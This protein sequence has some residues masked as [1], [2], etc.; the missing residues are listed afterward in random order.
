MP[1]E[2]TEHWRRFFGGVAD[3]I[4]TQLRPTTVLDA[5]CAKGFLVAAL[6]ERGVDATGFDLS[7]VAIK[8]APEAARDH[9]RV[10][11]LTEPIEGRYDL[12]T[13]VEVIEHL[14]PADAQTAIAN[15]AAASDQVLLSSTPGDRDEPTH[16]NI[17]PP[18][19]WTQMFAG[20]GMFRDFRHD[21]GYLSPW[22]VLYRRGDP[23]LVELVLDYDRAWS[24]LR[25][26]T[27]EQRRA[28][29]DLQRRLEEAQANATP[30]EVEHLRKEV[31]RLR[32]LVV[33]KDAELGTALGRIEELTAM[34]G[35]YA[36]LEQRLSDVLQSNSWRLTQAAALPLRKL[37]ERRG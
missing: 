37:R 35:R 9:V 21:A 12:V 15:L 29:L 4:V 25:A 7:D 28:L 27:I 20:H 6:R 14:D 19:R 36:N 31:L 22:A 34:L 2:D 23:S 11:S 3:A 26:E 1:Y 16:V 18:E 33:G 10:G 8:D 13:C 30:E 5:G 24:E 32:D 17:Q